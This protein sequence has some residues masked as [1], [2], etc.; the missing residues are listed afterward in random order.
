MYGSDGG[1]ASVR[2]LQYVGNGLEVGRPGLFVLVH[3]GQVGGRED[4][5]ELRAFDK[6]G[7]SVDLGRTK[8]KA[9]NSQ[10][11]ADVPP[12]WSTV[13]ASRSELVRPSRLCCLDRQ[14]DRRLR[15]TIDSRSCFR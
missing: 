1:G 2:R 13:E 14:P 15:C 7:L 4:R 10:G 9:G 3:A 8:I 6:R 5:V 11:V 12:R